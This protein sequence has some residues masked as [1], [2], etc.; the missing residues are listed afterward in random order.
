[1]MINKMLVV[2]CYSKTNYMFI[3]ASSTVSF[4][5]SANNGTLLHALASVLVVSLSSRITQK[6]QNE[7]PRIFD[8]G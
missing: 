4:F 2:I 1:M 8:G 3:S 7:F 6:I 5:L